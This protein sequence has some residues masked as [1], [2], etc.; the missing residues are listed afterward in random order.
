MKMSF[1]WYGTTDPVSLQNIRQI[2]GM[3]G[4]VSALYDVGI[5]N[6]W[7][8]EKIRSLKNAIES[9]GLAF[10]VVE[11][12]PVHEDIKLGKSNRDQLIA[13]YCQTL[14]HLSSAGIKVVCYNFMTV[15]DWMRTSLD[16]KL[17]D[18]SSCLDFDVDIASN[19]D[20]SEGIN[21]PGWDKQY[22]RDELRSLQKEYASVDED[23]LRRNLEYFL[24]RVIPVATEV[25][26]KMAI[27]PDDPPRSIFGLP[28]VVKNR[29]DLRRV[30]DM[31]D[32]PANGLTLC[33]GALG[34]D[35]NNDVV[36]MVREFGGEKRI[37]FAHMRNVHVDER[38]NFNETA[39]LSST[40]SL[41]MA[42]IVRAYND[43]GFEGYVRPD[44]GRMVWGETGNPGYGLYDRALG[45][46]YL[47]G[48]WEATQ[49]I[50]R[51]QRI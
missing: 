49:K 16:R 25:N 47:N 33:S 29:E 17:P 41:D 46:V 3:H 38:G 39:H 48:L 11:S 7:P 45:A 50:G 1:R 37:H 30:L 8:I 10:E 6:V 4:I 40:G 18:G 51:G 34:S 19:I 23:Q 14:R 9:H 43:V 27:H 12:V 26:I 28:R 35:I 22:T 15:F 44:H 31:V 13:N 24:Q 42:A 21:L 5:G 36:A 32:A 2:P 20:L